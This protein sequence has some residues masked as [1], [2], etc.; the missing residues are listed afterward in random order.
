MKKTHPI[1]PNL[2]IIVSIAAVFY[3]Y[4]KGL[5]QYAVLVIPSVIIMI[6]VAIFIKWNNNLY[7]KDLEGATIETTDGKRFHIT[8]RN[9]DIICFI[10]DLPEGFLIP[11][12]DTKG[13][14]SII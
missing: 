7:D 6:I 11:K 1:V 2:I 5:S 10:E 14:K 3:M 8:Y 12:I 9:Y 4:G 13:K